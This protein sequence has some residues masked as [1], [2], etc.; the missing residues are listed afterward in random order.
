MGIIY[1]YIKLMKREGLS[2]KQREVN[3]KVKTA[4]NKDGEK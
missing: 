1:V 2:E 3:Q 4:R